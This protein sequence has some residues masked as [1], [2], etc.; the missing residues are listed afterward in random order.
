[1][2]A[3]DSSILDERRRLRAEYKRR[4]SEIPSNLYAP[5]YP[6][7]SLMLSTRRRVAA[8][9]LNDSGV[10]PQRGDQCLEIGYGSL[11]W[12]GDLIAWGLREDDLC[13]VELDPARA[14]KAR[15]ALPAADLRVAGFRIQD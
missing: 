11:G 3:E 9:M 8:V 15:E 12:L 2:K 14:E 1:M 4:E 13:G 5:W 7:A 10:Y 6:P